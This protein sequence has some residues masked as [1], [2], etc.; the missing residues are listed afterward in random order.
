M[1][2]NLKITQL[3]ENTVNG[4]GLLGEHGNSFFIEADEYKLLFDTGQGLTLRHNSER[5]DIPVKSI[6]SI[7][8]SHGHYDHMGGLTEALDMTGPID[9]YLHPE[10]LGEKFNRNG[11]DIGAPMTDVTN[12]H[13]Q[14]REIIYTSKPTEITTGIHVTGEIPRKHVIEDTGG[15]FYIDQERIHSDSLVDD[16]ALFIETLQ[17]VVVLLG[18]GHSGVINT[19]EYVQALTGGK[20]IR[21]VIGGMHLLN[22]TAERLAFTGDALDHLSIP[23]LAPNHCTGVNAICYYQNRFAGCVHAS[24]VGSRHHFNIDI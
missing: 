2:K 18:C 8:V 21:A 24:H 22:A 6:Q 13:S 14:T 5:L 23:Y 4:P 7:V 11:R 15:P 16:Q 9:L 3:V 12:I 10:A 20:P 1:I 19:L 17:G